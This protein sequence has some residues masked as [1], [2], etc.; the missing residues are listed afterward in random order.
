MN[1]TLSTL[2]NSSLLAVGLAAG[3]SLIAASSANALKLDF[4]AY[5]GSTNDPATGAS[6][7]VKFDFLDVGDGTV[8]LDL[9]I[10]NN[11]GNVISKYQGND[12][13]TD[14]ATASKFMGFGLDWKDGD[15][16]DVF[17]ITSSD[18]TK[19]PDNY[20]GNIVFD[21]NTI[22][23]GIQNGIYNGTQFNDITFDI[24][25][26]QGNSLKNGQPNKALAQ[27]N[28]TTVSL[29]LDSDMDANATEQWFKDAFANKK[30]NAGARFQAVNA[31][32]GSDKLLGY[33]YEFSKNDP[34]VRV[35][36]PGSI[37]ALAFIGGG[38]FLSRRRQSN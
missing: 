12:I 15:L 34:P 21:D 23:G 10:T 24:G 6:A 7:E 9:N 2:V 4:N 17:G 27:G 5:Y 30:I 25:F 16:A 26:S 38:M 22:K 14:G 33:V 28:T 13:N 35:P 32:A 8:K 18:Y 19:D 20:F 3:S 37:A 31:G 36:E 1:K 11:T 29:I